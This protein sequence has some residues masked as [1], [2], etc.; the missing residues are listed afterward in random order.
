MW[1]YARHRLL[2]GKRPIDLIQTGQAEEVL[3][4]IES[5]DQSTYS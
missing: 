3:A 2:D 1:L 4:V 5:L